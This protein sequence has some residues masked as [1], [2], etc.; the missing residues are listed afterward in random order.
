MTVVACL[1]HSMRAFL[2]LR[3][4][5][6]MVML[7]QVVD[8][9]TELGFSEAVALAVGEGVMD[10]HS[11]SA[12]MFQVVASLLNTSGADPEAALRLLEEG[13]PEVRAPPRLGCGVVA[14]SE[15]TPTRNRAFFAGFPNATFSCRGAVVGAVVGAG[16]MLVCACLWMPA[17]C[18]PVGSGLSVL[19]SSPPW[20]PLWP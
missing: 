19:A 18:S 20:W 12:T 7:G 9:L 13:A 4:G 1:R 17:C 5:C 15:R 3:C 6:C 10:A 14:L 8:L 16:S 11:D 2:C